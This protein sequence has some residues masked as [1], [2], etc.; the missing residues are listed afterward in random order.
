[1]LDGSYLQLAMNTMRGFA[2]FY[3]TKIPLGAT[4]GNAPFIP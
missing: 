2:S 4:P 1:M 3:K